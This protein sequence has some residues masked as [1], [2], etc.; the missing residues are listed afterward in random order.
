MSEHK[1]SQDFHFEFEHHWGGERTQLQ[2]IKGWIAKQK[3]P[4]N[5]ILAALF[6]WVEKWYWDGKVIQ[7]MSNVDNQIE[8][9]HEAWDEEETMEP[10]Y[11]QEP[12]EVEGLDNISLKY[13]WPGPDQWYQGPLEIFEESEGRPEETRDRTEEEG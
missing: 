2:K 3:P 5:T 12:S 13:N 8:E 10:T 7:T 11:T 4:F 1:R 6:S 9:L